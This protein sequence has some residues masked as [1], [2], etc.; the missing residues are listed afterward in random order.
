MAPNTS[1]LS[2]IIDHHISSSSVTI[3]Y[4]QLS[5]PSSSINLYHHLSSHIIYHL[6]NIIYHLI[7]LLFVEYVEDDPSARLQ[8][9][10]RIC[11]CNAKVLS[12]H[13]L[14]V[15]Q[16]PNIIEACSAMQMPWYCH[17][18]A[19]AAIWLWQATAPSVPWQCHGRQHH[20]IAIV[21]P[22]QS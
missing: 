12:N 19:M 18:R 7:H 16:Y 2:I 14:I 1:K 9:G 10:F 6:S 4:H 22:L 21:A 5:C 20:A 3:Y 15:S 11:N 13:D 17:G 8:T